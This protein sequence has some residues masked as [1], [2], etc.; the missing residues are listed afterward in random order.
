MATELANSIENLVLIFFMLNFIW[1]IKTNLV[2]GFYAK[3]IKNFQC[4]CRFLDSDLI[5]LG[6]VSG[7]QGS[8]VEL[9][10]AKHALQYPAY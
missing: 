2:I 10:H 8:N 9:L 1:C 4:V 3:E 6:F 5:L 7:F